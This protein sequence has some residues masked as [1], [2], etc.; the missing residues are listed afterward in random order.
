MGVIRTDIASIGQAIAV[1]VLLAGVEGV[2]A[3]VNVAAEAVT[4]GIVMG[5]IRTD[6]AGFTD[7]IVI[8]VSLVGV[9]DK[10]TIIFSVQDAVVVVVIIAGVAA[11]VAVRVGLARVCDSG[12]VILS[13][14]YAVA[15]SV[16]K[17]IHAHINH[18][19][20][21]TITVRD[22]VISL[23]ISVWKVGSG[24]VTGVNGGRAKLQVVVAEL[25]VNK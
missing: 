3:I 12:A 14:A 2:R 13:V 16:D 7:T 22:S 1:P 10:R 21:V 5:V 23:E 4:V 15:I 24:V 11:A 25:S 8:T 20:A 9:G 6:I 18:C 19:A 17:L